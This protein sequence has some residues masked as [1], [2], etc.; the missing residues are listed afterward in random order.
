[1]T[2][3]Q[4]ASAFAAAGRQDELVLSVF[5]TGVTAGVALLSPSQVHAIGVKRGATWLPTS[6]RRSISTLTR[7]QVLV[8]TDI[9][10]AGPHGRPEHYW[11][12]SDAVERV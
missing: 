9:L 2:A 1:M 4:L 8:K 3:D 11:R 6:V 10:R 12:L 5:R 7:A